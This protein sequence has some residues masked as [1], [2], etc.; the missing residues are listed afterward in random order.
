MYTTMSLPDDL[1]NYNNIGRTGTY[2]SSKTSETVILAG[3]NP[4]CDT[5]AAQMYLRQ[6]VTDKWGAARGTPVWHNKG[7]DSLSLQVQVQPTICEVRGV[8]RQPAAE[9]LI[10]PPAGF[11]EIFTLWKRRENVRFS[12]RT[13]SPGTAAVCRCRR[14]CVRHLQ[15]RKVTAAA[16]L[17]LLR[18]A[19]FE[20]FSFKKKIF[21]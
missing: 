10:Y 11:E 19:A 2:G 16:S 9:V 21:L 3:D 5:V 17:R 7:D 15:A 12:T 18:P 14:P 13:R 6:K 20:C 4:R 8:E 1:G